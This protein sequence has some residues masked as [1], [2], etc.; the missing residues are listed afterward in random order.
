[1]TDNLKRKKAELTLLYAVPQISDAHPNSRLAGL[2]RKLQETIKPYLAQLDRFTDQD[3]HE[4][5]QGIFEWGKD[6]GWLDQKKCTGT[7][8]SFCLDMLEN[9]PIEYP[10]KIHQVLN[11]L[12]EHLE[13]GK[14]LYP[15]SCSAGQIAT[16]KWRKI[17][18]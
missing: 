18:E 4:I 7:L 8:V 11:Q 6:T 14:A 15:L 2:Q 1:M 13:N 10:Y 12:A 17:Y 16:E 3:L 5:N 9:S